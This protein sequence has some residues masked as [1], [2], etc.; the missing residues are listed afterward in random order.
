MT[1][2][3]AKSLLN[4]GGLIRLEDGVATIGN[5][6]VTKEFNTLMSRGKLRRVKY[7][8]LEDGFMISYYS[9]R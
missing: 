4:N 1:L 9:L 7:E 3:Q 2:L 6:D 5:N 8:L